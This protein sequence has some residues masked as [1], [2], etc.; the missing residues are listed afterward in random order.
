MNR[1]RKLE[2]KYFT[3]Q[4]PDYVEREKELHPYVHSRCFVTYP[5]RN[6][7]SALTSSIAQ[8]AIEHTVVTSKI[9]YIENSA[10]AVGTDVNHILELIKKGVKN[11]TTAEYSQL[12]SFYQTLDSLRTQ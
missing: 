11:F 1:N 9:R 7:K 12:N 10:K 2:L 8:L 4:Y 3:L 6:G 5:R